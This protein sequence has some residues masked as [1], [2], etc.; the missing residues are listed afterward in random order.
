MA[1]KYIIMQAIPQIFTQMEKIA[2][3]ENRH[4][5]EIIAMLWSRYHGDYTEY[6]V[7]TGVYDGDGGQLL[8]AYRKGARINTDAQY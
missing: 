2:E 6:T 3:C 4:D 5:A 8:C 7:N 1:K